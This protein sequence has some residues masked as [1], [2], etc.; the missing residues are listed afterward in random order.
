MSSTAISENTMLLVQ[1]DSEVRVPS[2]E[3]FAYR[4][5]IQ[6]LFLYLLIYSPMLIQTALGKYFI[7]L[8]QNRRHLGKTEYMNA[9]SV[10]IPHPYFM[11][12]GSSNNVRVRLV[13]YLICCRV[14]W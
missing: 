4:S 2:T 12:E 5:S 14:E 11:F 13:Q 8:F 10:Q 7:S 1:K 9:Y 3:Q 6:M